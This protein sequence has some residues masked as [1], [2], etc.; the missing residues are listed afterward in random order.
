MRPNVASPAE[1]LDAGRRI[2]DPTLNPYG[3]H[4]APEPNRASVAFAV[5]RSSREERSL[6][7]HVRRQLGL[8]IYHV[9]AY[10]FTHETYMRY[11]GVH[12]EARFPRF[13]ADPLEG[14]RFLTEDIARFCDD[15][16]EGKG[17]QFRTYAIENQKDPDRFRG[18][19]GLSRKRDR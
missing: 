3:F 19:R 9:G 13:S 12:G 15:F 5:G 4:F 7:L 8:V 18:Q 6:E 10:R 1:I 17:I 14:F 16:L 11:L 2:L